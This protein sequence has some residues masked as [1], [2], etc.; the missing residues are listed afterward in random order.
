MHVGTLVEVFET[1]LLVG[2][3]QAVV[4]SRRRA[5]ISHFFARNLRGVIQSDL[6]AL[7]LSRPEQYLRLQEKIAANLT[8]TVALRSHG[9]GLDVAH[10][11]ARARLEQLA[12]AY[13]IL[14][15]FQ[16][17][18]AVADAFEQG[19]APRGAASSWH[20]QALDQD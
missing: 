16:E 1:Y 13:A 5:T 2:F 7:G 18:G 6:P 3:P 8:S 15:L 19:R 14:V 17:S 12:N 9:L 11:T 20:A 4:D 10:T